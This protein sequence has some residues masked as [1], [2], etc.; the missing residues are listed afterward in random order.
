MAAG[1]LAGGLL[2]GLLLGLPVLA[3]AGAALGLLVYATIYLYNT[4]NKL[5]PK[6]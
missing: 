6:S 1:A 3:M 4:Q 2:G 5:Q